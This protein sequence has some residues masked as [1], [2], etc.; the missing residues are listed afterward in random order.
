[1]EV[2]RDAAQAGYEVI[3]AP[4]MPTYF[5]YA[6][7]GDP[8]E[9]LAIGGT[10]VTIE[11]VAAFRP[12]PGEWSPDEAARLLGAQFQLWTE[13][14]ADPPALEYMAFPRACAFAEVAWTGKP[15]PWDASDEPGRP[16]LRDRLAAH[17]PR[18]TAAGTTFRPLTIPEAAKLH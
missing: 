4:V 15:A 9:P 6:Q 17:L 10:P 2:A 18:L 5:D 7:P 8:A 3:A 16:P 11:D 12:L 13:Y 14:I 1:M